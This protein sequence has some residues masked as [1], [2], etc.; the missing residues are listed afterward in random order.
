METCYSWKTKRF[1]SVS[2]KFLF[3]ETGRILQDACQYEYKYIIKQKILITK[4]II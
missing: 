2:D 4:K 1:F 3:I